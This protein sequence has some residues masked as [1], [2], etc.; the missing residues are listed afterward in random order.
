MENSKAFYCSRWK[1]G[2]KLTW[3]KNGLK[4]AG[5]PILTERIVKELLEK[6]SVRGRTGTIVMGQD[7]GLSFE[8]KEEKSQ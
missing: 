1:E 2:C 3:W 5:G 4:R 8:K 7:K 6:G